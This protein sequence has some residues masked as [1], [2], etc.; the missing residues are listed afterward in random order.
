MLLAKPVRRRPPGKS[1]VY[2]DLQVSRQAKACSDR[3][4]HM[5]GSFL[6]QVTFANETLS[7]V[8]YDDQVGNSD[9][10]QATNMLK[11]AAAVILAGSF[12]AVD[13]ADA[14]SASRMNR[15]KTVMEVRFGILP[16]GTATFDIEYD[17][18]HYVLGAAGKTVG[19][20]DM[21]APGKGK[22]ES[23]G[24]IDGSKVIATRH[25]VE[26]IEKKKNKK[27]TLDMEFDNG[28]VK[29]VLLVPD[30]R[31]RKK[32][33]K[34]VE[35]T[36]DQLRSVIDPASGIIIPVTPDS[37]KDPRSVCNRELNIYDGDTRYD[38]R[39]KY[40]STMP[41]STEGFN[42]DAF[43]C[44]LRY[45][46]VAGHKK[47]QRNVEYM[48]KNEEIEIWLAPMEDSNLYTPI[49]IEVPT[50]VGTFSAV[51]S[52]FGSFPEQPALVRSDQNELDDPSI[53]GK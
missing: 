3:Q 27:S 20:V 33:P 35:L 40:K 12:L 41:I 4:Q 45:V 48:R 18:R 2:S 23:A 49:R 50:W 31:K 30:K 47:K 17:E 44:Q 36:A 25:S 32:S 26:Y 14:A 52:Y 10:T 37:A 9:M 43:V 16:V 38:I 29:S 13:C 8:G 19:V 53:A 15:H 28:A 7:F 42:G 39:L 6:V 34:W 46:P 24:L 5:S 51:P 21:L 1:R 11:V 22:A